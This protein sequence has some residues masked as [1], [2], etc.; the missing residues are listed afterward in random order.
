MIKVVIFDLGDTIFLATKAIDK[1]IKIAPDLKVLNSFGHNFSK[2]DYVNA[3]HFMEKKFR[4]LSEKQK[5]K[6]LIFSQL[7][8]EGFGL[9]PSN[10]IAKKMN[11]AFRKETVKQIKMLPNA[12]NILNYLKKN[13]I[14][15][16][17]ISNAYT[18]NGKHFLKKHKLRK[19]FKH[20]LVSCDIG[21]RK[22]EVEPFH[23]LLRKL[24][25]NRKRRIK[26]QECLMIGDNVK[27]DAA[28]KLAGMKV[29]ILIP[30]MNHKEHLEILKPDY[31]I[32]D[33][34]E[35]KTIVE[36]ENSV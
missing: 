7:A 11:N 26:P 24:N 30:T 27:E 12:K 2:K 25:K 19:Y 17:V 36:K 13:G 32:N 4:T 6:N 22:H 28:A 31:L 5:I 20:V 35:V 33:L 21:F 29:A 1:T 18:N 16:T 8:M 23:I 9:K 10:T 14:I 15:L 3:R 34:M